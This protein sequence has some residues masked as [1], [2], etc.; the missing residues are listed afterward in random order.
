[1]LARIWNGW[2]ILLE[3]P[4][5]P[6]DVPNNRQIKLKGPNRFWWFKVWDQNLN[7][8]IKNMQSVTVC[9]VYLFIL[10]NVIVLTRNKPLDIY[11]GCPGYLTPSRDLIYYSISAKVLQFTSAELFSTFSGKYLP[12]I[13]K[14]LYGVRKKS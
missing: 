4:S 13:Y 2:H 3:T 14:L 6:G 12:L 10:R 5:F 9:L 1:M 7:Y 8:S 11:K